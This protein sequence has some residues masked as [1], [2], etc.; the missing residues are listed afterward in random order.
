MS[1][2]EELLAGFPAA[3]RAA[4]LP[5]DPA[6]G[7]RLPA[8]G[9][10]RPAARRRRPRPDR[11]RDAD[12]I[13]R[14]VRRLRRGLRRLVRRRGRGPDACARGGG[15]GAAARPPGARRRWCRWPAAPPP[16]AP[17]RPTRS[18]ERRRSARR[19]RTSAA[20][21]TALRRDFATLP[22]VRRRRWVPAPA[23]PRLDV[24]RTARAARRTFG[25]TLRLLAPGARGAAAADAA[26]R[27]RLGVDAG[28]VGDHPALRPG[29]DPGA[30]A[31]RDLHLRHPPDPGHRRAQAA[32]RRG[33]AGAARRRRSAT[34][35]AA[36]ASASRSRRSSPP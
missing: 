27:R 30:R 13:A 17:P 15:R 29:A 18:P 5:V 36:P 10:L 9:A 7:R 21:S 14:G 22:E 11:P 33:G 34:S 19:P 3:L 8:G 1:P 23:G 20:R 4:G 32:R 28:A 16:D 24:P 6:R 35:T 12:R 26:A 25:E 31:G 2:A